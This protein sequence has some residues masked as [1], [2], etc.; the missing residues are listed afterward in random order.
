MSDKDFMA[1]IND[2]ATSAT[3]ATRAITFTKNGA[4]ITRGAKDALAQAPE[5]SAKL[6]ISSKGNMPNALARAFYNNADAQ[7]KLASL[8]ETYNIS[9]NAR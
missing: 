6:H 5:L 1:F 2:N 7:A 3:R 8:L 9:V 4:S